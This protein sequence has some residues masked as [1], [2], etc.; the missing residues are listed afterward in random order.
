M[1]V[2]KIF[3]S[4][5]QF[6][7]EVDSEAHKFLNVLLTKKVGRKTDFYFECFKDTYKASLG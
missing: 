3:S 4:I 2:F 5:E 7:V 6:P 1:V